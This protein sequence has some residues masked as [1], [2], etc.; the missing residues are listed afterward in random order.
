M[1]ISS[2]GAW[3][4]LDHEEDLF[5]QEKVRGLGGPFPQILD[6]GEVR[7]PYIYKERIEEFNRNRKTH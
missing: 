5:Y 6:S 1:N 2:D 3:I 4:E 7:I